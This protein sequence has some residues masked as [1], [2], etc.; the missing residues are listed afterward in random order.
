MRCKYMLIYLGLGLFSGSRWLNVVR[1]A[2]A[3]EIPILR[4]EKLK[5]KGEV[6]H[7]PI[8]IRLVALRRDNNHFPN[9][10]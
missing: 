1:L 8:D 5:W 2:N 7:L 3:V 10:D 6:V 9:P 4:F